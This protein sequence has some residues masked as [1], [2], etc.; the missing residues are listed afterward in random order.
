MKYVTAELG[1]GVYAIAV[2]DKGTWGTPTY[3]NLYVVKRQGQ[4]I[5]IDAG[6]PA[7]K[8][9]VETALGT[10]GIKPSDVTH[11]LL[12]HG[13]GDHSAGAS[14]FREAQK[15]VHPLDASLVYCKLRPEFKSY[16]QGKNANSFFAEGL[17]DFDVM[18]VGS[19]TPGSVVIYDQVSRVMFA[20]DFF[21]YFGE[22][23]PEGKLVSFAE[24]CRQASY[25]YVA[26]QAAGG[27]SEA[28]AFKIGMERLLS[29][30]PDF[31]C[32]GHGVILQ[33][34]IHEFLQGLWNSTRK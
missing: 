19:H 2:E 12:T 9:V 25:Q 18:H 26:D 30:R 4:V 11:V 23:L 14:L 29:Y 31:F 34:E 1:Q 15:Y 10:I 17:D 16:T 28:A 3:A 20:G 32:T 22:E 6:L 13:H 8:A 7:Y 5:M 27:G 33:G 21:C 24:N